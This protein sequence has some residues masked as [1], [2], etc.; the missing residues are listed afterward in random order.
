MEPGEPCQPPTTATTRQPLPRPPDHSHAG[1]GPRPTPQ[2]PDPRNHHDASPST[3]L[4]AHPEKH[5]PRSTTNHDRP[6]PYADSL[7]PIEDDTHTASTP[8]QLRPPEPPL[9][10]EVGRSQHGLA[11]AAT[12]SVRVRQ[13]LVDS[14]GQQRR[15]HTAHHDISPDVD[16]LRPDEPQTRKES[17]KTLIQKR[18]PGSSTSHRR[19]RT[20]TPTS[21]W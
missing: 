20:D 1:L 17:L 14:D 11:L 19:G 3:A 2:P 6:R 15:D 4:A 18:G 21:Y 8:N 7:C 5:S 12:V 13:F 10:N 16:R 9:S